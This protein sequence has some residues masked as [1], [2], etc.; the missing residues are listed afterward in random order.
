MALVLCSNTSMSPL[1]L[2][3]SI[4]VYAQDEKCTYAISDRRDTVQSDE[5]N[6]RP[7]L[8]SLSVQYSVQNVRRQES[9]FPCNVG[10]REIMITGH[11]P[12]AWRQDSETV[13]GFFLPVARD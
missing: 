1:F 2:A 10:S 4:Q 3:F 13:T 8:P 9:M 12:R 5:A 11:E 7:F 6:K